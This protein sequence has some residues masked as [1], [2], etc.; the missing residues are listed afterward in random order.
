MSE[1]GNRLAVS[2]RRVGDVA[3]SILDW[4]GESD[5]I[6]A[7]ERVA[8][9]HEIY[10]TETT[11]STLVRAL[12]EGPAVAIVGP[13][14]AGKTQLLA[15]LAERDGGTVSIRFE[16]IR[17]QVGLIKYLCPEGARAGRSAVLRLTAR[18]RPASQN[19]PVVVRL[20]SMADLVKIL[21]AMFL[22]GAEA[23][24]LEPRPSRIDHA[25]AEARRKV[26]PEPVAG[27]AEE[28]I[29]DIRHY[30]TTRFGDEPLIR[31]LLTSGYWESLTGIAGHLA[32]ADR[33]R[34]LSVLWGGDERLTEVFRSLA[35]AVASLGC[36]REA[37]C[38]LDAVLGLDP[39]TGRFQRRPDS[40]INASTLNALGRPDAETLVVS[41]EAGQWVSLPRPVLA[42]VVAEVR[43]PVADSGAALLDRAD[44]LEFPAI[45]GLNAGGHAM[46]EIGRDAGQLGPVFM[47]AK[48]SYLLERYTDEQAVTAMVVCVDPSSPRLRELGGL[49]T[50]WIEKSHGTDPATR[51]RQANGLFVC[52]TKLD[53][54]FQEPA[55]RG[56]ERR[57]DWGRHVTAAL[58]QGLGLG[59]AWAQEWT[60][61][62]A[63]DNLHL[64]RLPGPK[65]KHL[66]AYAGDGREIGY[67][68]EQTGRIERARRDFLAAP[69][70]QRHVADP[71][72]VW[73]EALELNDGGTAYLAQSLVDVCDRHAKH[74]HILADLT[75]LGRQLKDR[76]QRYHVSDDPGLQQDRRR[77]SAVIAVRWLRRSA[78]QHRL[79]RLVGGLQ[80]PDDE[81]HDV[82]RR[83]EAERQSAGHSAGAKV[84]G[85]AF[86]ASPA[87]NGE[88]GAMAAAP[89]RRGA[90]PTVGTNGQLPTAAQTARTFA[91]LAM[92]HW[93]A[94]VRLFAQAERIAQTLQ[95]PRQG[96]AL[97]VD[98]LIAGAGRLDL[99]ARI[100]AEIETLIADDPS[101]EHQTP[102]AALVAANLIGDY[103]M[104]LGFD[105][106]RSN[107]HPRRK[108]RAGA[109][110]FPPKDAT[111]AFAA[112]ET[113]AQAERAFLTDWSQAFL[114]L[115][116]GNAE[117]LGR[118]P[119][120]AERNRRLGAYLAD[121]NVTL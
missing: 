82:L 57:I 51:E 23:P 66:L 56:K 53:K 104:W 89:E 121:L 92:T 73:Q 70:V 78:E 30:F 68:P 50:A 3:K 21:G 77:M 87:V 98:E 35:D 91:A 59:H 85:H 34:V 14:R 108:G 64:L 44:L 58:G 54:E 16:G 97:I 39:R 55:R 106:V 95:I 119:L 38:A 99:E 48:S 118:R 94:S 80:L 7:A 20:L 112:A 81:F 19:F 4:V 84:N 76:L 41:N 114:A 22:T 116:A 115:V 33:A 120:D 17:E 107:A 67:K 63:F 29:W 15:S 109:P 69:E 24:A 93:V 79:G 2:C 27:L 42:A 31:L 9:L 46:R 117:D 96:L 105:D 83:H 61:G 65:A 100:A 71:A 43:L 10:R 102:R 103:V 18:A 86:A 40:I 60:P 52:L 11:A 113:D 26:R 72:T 111:D 8:L 101:S 37:R 47:R 45:D 62:R 36:E 12:D 75:E 90:K 28:D 6:I 5:Q 88:A 1:A 32:N 25:L 13:S 110:I 74:R 49:V